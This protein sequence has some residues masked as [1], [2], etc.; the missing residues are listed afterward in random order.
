VYKP[1]P[2]TL[3]IKDSPIHG[4]GLYATES[5]PNGTELG[6]SHI[7][8]VGF[9]NNY[10]RTP[11]GGFV[12]HSDDPNCGKIESHNDST[13]TYYILQTIKDIKEGEELTL[14]YT[15]YSV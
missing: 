13:L 5:I 15:M 10:V 8:A 7:F 12:N 9:Q 6:I 3:T 14:D 2:K 11:L 4:Q 1:L